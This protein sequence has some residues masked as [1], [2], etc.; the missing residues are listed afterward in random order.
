MARLVRPDALYKQLATELREAIHKGDYPPGTLLPSE[1]TLVE[2]YGVSKPTVRLALSA[3]RGEGLIKVVNGK[4]SYVRDTGG[5]AP[6]TIV[7]RGIRDP[8]HG[9]HPTGEP[10]QSRQEADPRLAALL[11]IQAGEP[12]FIQDQTTQ[13]L[14]TGRTILTRRITPFTVAEGTSLETRPYPDRTELLNTLREVY[15][16]LTT[17]L[18]TR[19]CLPRPDQAT[20]LNML[21][22]TPVLETTWLTLA[23]DGRVLLA[24]TETTNAEGIYMGFS[25]CGN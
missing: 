10:E 4:G 13:D 19:A 25:S 9:I 1:N 5:N 15:G 14:T 23:P 11:G 3:L 24:E 18:Y 21:D 7:H 12:L 2:R 8:W 16:E 22:A 20:A 17:Q 6:A